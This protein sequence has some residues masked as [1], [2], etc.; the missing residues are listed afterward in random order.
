MAGNPS[1]SLKETLTRLKNEVILGN[2]YTELA[3]GLRAADPVVFRSAGTFFGLTL[4][5]SLQWSQMIAARL[6]DTTP[7]TVTVRS[8]LS[9]AEKQI[10]SFRNGTQAQV[11]RAIRSSEQRIASLQPI[12]RS[13]RDRRNKA[14]AHLD[15]ET[16]RNPRALV[17]KAKL[18]MPDLEKVFGET[19]VILADISSLYDGSGG[20]LRLIDG[21][22]Y[23]KALDYIADAKCAQADNY[24]REFHVPA[25][26]S[27]PRK[28]R[29]TK[30]TP[31]ASGS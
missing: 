21:D 5:G 19:E 9:D 23:K 7:G 25:P 10:S 3:K 14:L 26:F 27:R 30:N 31:A 8:L 6:Y 1:P 18:T 2:A 11:R 17:R 12:L 29:P 28:C 22:D 4:D 20:A 16:V 15:P 13:I 24:E